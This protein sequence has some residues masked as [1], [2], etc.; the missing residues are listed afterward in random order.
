MMSNK[1]KS[2]K[3]EVLVKDIGYI[4]AD[5]EGVEGQGQD[6]AEAV[7]V[8]HIIHRHRQQHSHDDI[9]GNA[10]QRIVER[11]VFLSH[12]VG[13]DHRHAI[14]GHTSPGTGHIAIL[15]H[16]DDVHNQ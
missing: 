3:G 6:G 5:A 10:F 15:W 7:G 12:E 13:S 8:W 14:A 2:A 9:D 11:V 4:A 16:E 1:G